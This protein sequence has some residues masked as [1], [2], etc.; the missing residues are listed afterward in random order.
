[1]VAKSFQQY[2]VIEGP[3]TKNNK[4]YVIIATKTNPRKE[5]RWYSETE[6]LKLY[7]PKLEE[8]KFDA[9]KAFGFDKGILTVFTGGEDDPAVEEIFKKSSARYATFFGWYV[10]AGDPIPE[11][12]K[13]V[14]KIPVSWEDV[15][16]NDIFLPAE[17]VKTIVD[18]FKKY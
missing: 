10:I 18:T 1:M 12:P 14:H 3:Y 4:Q 11:L 16:H 8:L 15:S 13:Y 7:P 17:K 9:K 6:Y 2:P 5:V